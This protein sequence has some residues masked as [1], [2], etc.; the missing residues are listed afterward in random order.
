[1]VNKT[2]THQLLEELADTAKI[3]DIQ[4]RL[5]DSATLLV[6]YPDASSDQS[7]E[8]MNVI[9]CCRIELRRRF[10]HKRLTG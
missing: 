2:F 3:S 10:Y 8:W 6:A 4:K 9:D 7:E 1:M 5:Q